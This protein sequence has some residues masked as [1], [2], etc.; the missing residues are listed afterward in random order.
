MFKRSSHKNESLSYNIFPKQSFIDC[1]I[2]QCGWEACIP[3]YLYGPINLNNYLFHYVLS[4]KGT[5]RTVD[6]FGNV[7]SYDIVAGQ[8]F[9]INP[10]KSASYVADDNDPW[11]Y[12][13]VEFDGIKAKE[14]IDLAGLSLDNPIYIGDGSLMQHTMKDE[15]LHLTNQGD[16]GMFYVIGHLYLFL[17]AL[18]KS[19]TNKR[20][21]KRDSIND[22]YVNEAIAFIEINYNSDITVED[23]ADICGLNRNHFSKIFKQIVQI[24]PQQFII[25]YRMNKA[26]EF[27]ADR[28]LSV[29]EVGCLVGYKHPLRFSRAFKTTF[30]VSPREWRNNNVVNTSPYTLHELQSSHLPSL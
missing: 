23:L 6:S 9:L 7:K 2:I 5:F 15:M 3:S 20:I 17:Y 14:I 16:Q 10:H 19:S 28:K 25:R 26:C 18:Y 13:W 8:G 30:G 21:E 4:G 1:N 12:T 11:E 22:F 24:T 29:T 27:L